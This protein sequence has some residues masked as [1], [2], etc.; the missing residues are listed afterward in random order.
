MQ[1]LNITSQSGCYFE[2]GLTLPA[3]CEFA[4]DDSV[5]VHLFVAAQNDHGTVAY[6]V[7]AKLLVLHLT[8][9]ESVP[10]ALAI[11]SHA[12]EEMDQL[13]TD[14]LVYDL[15]NPHLVAGTA[16]DAAVQKYLLESHRVSFLGV[17]INPGVTPVECEEVQLLLEKYK[18]E[19]VYA[20]TFTQLATTLKARGPALAK[21]CAVVGDVA[22]FQANYGG[23]SFSLPELKATVIRTSGSGL[24][25]LHF[26]K[27]FRA[28]LE[29]HVKNKASTL[30]L[31]TCDSPPITDLDQYARFHTS[32]IA[33]MAAPGLASTVIH[34]HGGN[35]FRLKVEGM[36]E[37]FF[38]SKNVF[39]CEANSLEAAL[40]L[41]RVLKGCCTT[42][43]PVL[44]RVLV[45]L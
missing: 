35:P 19:R 23:S 13:N 41:V 38:A 7:D 10:Q 24:N 33:P 37:T 15:R 8:G 1:T 40:G 5:P 45:Q 34:V 20:Q 31:D 9:T 11:A 42:S 43:A 16:V 32:V 2:G 21:A 17:L 18:F 26:Q 30:I 14:A 27:L 6:N 39:S 3:T 22:D 29:L 25:P 4:T 28:A 12:L 36:I 44:P